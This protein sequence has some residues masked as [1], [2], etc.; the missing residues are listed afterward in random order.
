[1]TEDQEL[2]SFSHKRNQDRIQREEKELEA[3]LA[4][5]LGT[6]KEEPEAQEV[7]QEERQETPVVEAEKVETTEKPEAEEELSEED[8]T[9]KKRYGDL[10][11]LMQRKEAE[12]KEKEQTYLAQIE[13]AKQNAIELPKTQTDVQ[14]WVKKYPEAASVI[15]AIAAQKAQENDAKLD[16]R[17]KEIEKMEAKAK[18]QRA[19]AELMAIHPDFVS[20][21]DDDAFHDWAE[22]QPKLVQ[23]ALYSK[24]STVEE[25]AYVISSYKNA[26]GIKPKGTSTADEKAAASSVKP[27]TK[28]A[29]VKDTVE[30]AF[31]ESSVAKMSDKE[32]EKNYDKIIQA[33]R[34]GKFVYDLKK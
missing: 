2:T 8:K 10:R 20:I 15:E 26:M 28:T 31:S 5:H 19:E 7:E 1:M 14:E 25:I 9:F 6:K 24:D 18:R 16:A 33:Q 22:K 17:L 4:E 12:W 29:V 32:F 30:P 23:N 11:A 21:R 3:L 34:E 27:R 13:E